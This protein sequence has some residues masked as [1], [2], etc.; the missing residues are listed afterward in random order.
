MRVLLKAVGGFFRRVKFEL[1]EKTKRERKNH[2][3]NNTFLAAPCNRSNN[4][5][6]QWVSS[7][8]FA[9]SNALFLLLR[10]WTISGNSF[11]HYNWG[12]ARIT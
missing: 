5:S 4:T 1:G 12:V 7:R 2:L 3:G 8:D 10:I 6:H 11:D 9:L